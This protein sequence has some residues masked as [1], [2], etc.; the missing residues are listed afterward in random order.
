MAVSW[1]RVYSI[2]YYC[3][4]F[5]WL[6]CPD[7]A[8]ALMRAQTVWF[9]DMD[10]S[11]T[12]IGKMYDSVAREYA[13][14]FSREHE[15]KPKDR[16]MLREFARKIG[17]R[18]P[19]WDI[20]CGPGHTAAYLRALGVAISGLDLSEG[21]LEEA[22]TSHPDLR[23][24]KGNILDLEF[25]NDSMAGAVAFY[26]IVHFTPE[27]VGRAFHE[28]FRVLRPGGEF[29]VAYHIG[30]ETIHLTEFL[31]KR[32]DIDIMFFN[33]KF[34]SGSLRDSGFERIET[35]EREPYPDVEYQS[36]RAYVFARKPAA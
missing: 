19:V 24:Q 36:R 34:I 32:I 27:Q 15:K 4:K 26:A 29:L 3:K 25:E 2:Q 20:G 30:E 17:N 18:G 5:T 6:Q 10:A 11:V 16:D 14:T 22:R 35:T 1:C 9:A 12:R 28:V 23:F 8:V 31:G 33:T 13:E 21:I 7:D